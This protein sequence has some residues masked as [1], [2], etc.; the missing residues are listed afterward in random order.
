[1]SE[2]ITNAASALSDW[3]IWKAG[4]LVIV[5]FVGM[6]LRW[7]GIRDNKSAPPT[8]HHQVW[9]EMPMFLMAH[10]VTKSIAVVEAE[11]RKM[12]AILEDIAK[13]VRSFNLGQEHTHRLLEDIRNNHQ[14]RETMA[15]APARPQ[16]ATRDT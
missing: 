12:V 4:F 1:M 7:L 2:L 13:G 10:D 14:L 6:F 3:P 9:G 15:H 11:N 16:R 8:P 5:V